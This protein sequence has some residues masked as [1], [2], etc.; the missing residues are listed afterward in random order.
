MKT[1]VYNRQ[2]EINKYLKKF[3]TPFEM[4]DDAIDT[5]TMA[6]NYDNGIIPLQDI[7]DAIGIALGPNKKPIP[8]PDPYD[9][10]EGVVKFA[11]VEWNQ[12]F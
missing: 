10:R 7:A 9:P 5:R 3:K 6:E 11:Y 8:T 12:N 2:V 1:K 4:K